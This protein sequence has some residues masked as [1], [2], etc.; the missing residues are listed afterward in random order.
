MKMNSWYKILLGFKSGYFPNYEYGL[1]P[2]FIVGACQIPI[3]K[4]FET[5]E[6]AKQTTKQMFDEMRSFEN[7]KFIVISTLCD[8]HKGDVLNLSEQ[9]NVTNAINPTFEE[10]WER[11]GSEIIAGDYHISQQEGEIVEQIFREL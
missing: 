4:K 9:I 8:K 7:G 1:T 6:L 2:R 3:R 10:I 11:Y 5:P